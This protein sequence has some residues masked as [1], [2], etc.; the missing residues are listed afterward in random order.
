MKAEVN[1]TRLSGV[2]AAMAVALAVLATLSGS[3]LGQRYLPTVDYSKAAVIPEPMRLEW[4]VSESFP[5]SSTTVVVLPE[6]SSEEA[7]HLADG[8]CGAMLDLWGLPVRLLVTDLVPEKNAIV[9]GTM[10]DSTVLRGL[11]PA[12]PRE[13]FGRYYEQGYVMSTSPNRAVVVGMSEEGLKYGIQTLMQL[14]T[15]DVRIKQFVIPSVEVVDFPATDMRGLLMPFDD[16]RVVSPMYN[17]REFIM[18]AEMLHFNT[19]FFVIDNTTK[20]ETVPGIAAGGAASKDTLRTMAEYARSFGLEVV[21]YVVTL[22]QQGSL[23]CAIPSQLCLDNDMYNPDNPQVYDYLFGI[24]DEVIEACEPTYIHIG[25][26]EVRGLHKLPEAEAQ[27]LF[28]KDVREIHNYLKSKNI[29]TMMWAD[30]LLYSQ[31]FHGQDNCYGMLGQIQAVIDSLPKDIILVDSHDRQSRPDF[32]SLDYLISKGF[33]VVAGVSGNPTVAQNFSNY[34]TKKEAGVEGM[35]LSLWGV[36]KLE[37]VSSL[38]RTIWHTANAFWRGGVPPEDPKGLK[39][40]PGQR[41]I[42]Y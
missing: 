15:V 6:G 3:A 8:L 29:K 19:V 25:H 27:R 36:F 10:R 42:R 22:G 24:L 32:P 37:G 9:V 17:P 18:V 4:K 11:F 41:N 1:R 13:Q 23:L 20:F 30:M 16:N 38:K 39:R 35:L 31:E 40:P 7:R 2:V 28:I 34:A 12:I 33:Q 5:L 14:V 26:S 21:P